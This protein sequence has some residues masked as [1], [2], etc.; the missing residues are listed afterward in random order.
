MVLL[1]IQK[2]YQTTTQAIKKKD[3]TNSV[4]MKT[5]LS[6]RNSNKDYMRNIKHQFRD[7]FRKDLFSFALCSSGYSR[8]RVENL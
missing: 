1:K 5:K 3:E 8:D 4:H 2:K 6:H 7:W